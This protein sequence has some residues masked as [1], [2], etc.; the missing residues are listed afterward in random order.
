MLSPWQTPK[1]LFMTANTRSMVLRR[2]LIILSSNLTI[3]S[4]TTKLMKN[5]TFSKSDQFWILS[6]IKVLSLSL[7]MGKLAQVKLTP[8]TDCRTLLSRISLIEVLTTGRTI[9]VILQSLFQ[10][11]KFMVVNFMIFS[12]IISN[13]NSKKIKMVWSKFLASKSNLSTMM[14]IS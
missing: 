5:Y 3:H 6:S 11:M 10:C 4:L 8:W 12:M 14:I 13:W 7:H 1:S 2:W 9:S